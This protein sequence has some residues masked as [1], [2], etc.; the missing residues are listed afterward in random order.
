MQPDIDELQRFYASRQGQLARRLIQRQLRL[1]WPDLSGL[2]V[3]GL[4]YA[5]PYLTGLDSTLRSI[6][7]MPI[8][9]GVARWPSEGRG[10]SALVR[11][12]DLPLADGSV[13]RMLLVHGLECCSNVPRLM[14][15]V[16]RVLAD[17]GRVVAVLPNRRGL[18]SLSDRTPFGHGQPYSSGQL[19]RMLKGHLF[20]PRAERSA[21][22][23]PP[24]ESRFLLR[25]AI[26]VERIGLTVARRFAGVVLVEAEKQ[27][28]VGTAV[29][30][31]TR[32][33]A[34][35]YVPVMDALTGAARSSHPDHPEAAAPPPALWRETPRA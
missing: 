13:E 4:G 14:R 23:L 22:F 7:F 26:P 31:Q 15:E 1:L 27:I 9:Q 6:A 17:G 28:Y 33:Q 21:L 32:R 34:R 16:W 35:R 20:T 12:D 25:L 10:R 29:S 8:S 18:W 3:L 5:A 30:S 19:E 2:N 11:E 24:T